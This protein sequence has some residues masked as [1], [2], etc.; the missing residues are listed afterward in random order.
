VLVAH[1]LTVLALRRSVVGAFALA[2][3]AITVGFAPFLPVALLHAH[4]SGGF[5][6]HVTFV[7]ALRQIADAVL[8]V[9][10]PHA[11]EW[12]GSLKIAGSFLAAVLLVALPVF[13]RASIPAEPA[14]GVVVQWLMSLAIFSVLFT[15]AGV[16]PIPTKYLIVIGPSTLLA[17]FLFVSSLK[18]FPALGAGAAAVVYAFFTITAL[19]MQYRPPLQKPGDWQR[20][21][22]A[23]S[24]GGGSIPVAVFPAEL[25]QPLSW[26]YPGAT[27]A[28]PGPMPFT[29][30][31]VGAMALPNSA[32][33]ARVLDPIRARSEQLWMVTTDDCQQGPPA[34]YDYHCRYL[35]AYLN[36]R[37]RIVRSVAFRGSL[38]RLYARTRD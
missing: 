21:A 26:Y 7:H 14:R 18:R 9:L 5:V 19:W 28:I 3:A 33:V 16:P 30:D 15:A 25:A 34:L 1:G 24:G 2:A 10:F 35:E 32:E 22:A 36:R 13:G 8:V 20:L 23:V 27:V 29:L 6:V 12:S 37:Y 17:G 4:A 38:A 11:D 31:Y